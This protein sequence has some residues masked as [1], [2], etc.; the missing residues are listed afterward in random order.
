VARSALTI[1]EMAWANDTSLILPASFQFYRQLKVALQAQRQENGT[2]VSNFAPSSQYF[3]C[4]LFAVI[5]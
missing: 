2:A 1:S 5:G 3:T 4:S